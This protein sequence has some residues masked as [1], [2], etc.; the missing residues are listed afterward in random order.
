MNTT[1]LQ[2]RGL[3]QH[4][5]G[6]RALDGV[7]F[8]VSAGQ[9][10]ALI[11]PNGAGKSTCFA[12]LAG[13]QVPTAG[14][15]LWQGQ[16]LMGKPPAERQRL[17]VARTFQVAQTFEA[18]TVLQNIQ[19]VLRSA[20]PLAWWDRLDRRQPERALHLAAQA[21]LQSQAHA[22]VADLPYGAKKRLE[23]A[24]A[25]AGLP[26]AMPGQDAHCAPSLLLL[27]EP[28]AGLALAERADMMALVRQVAAQGVTVLYT[29][30][31]MDAV[32]GVADRVLVL[33]QG[34][35]VA[36]GLPDVVAQDPQVLQHYLGVNF[37]TAA[38]QANAL[39]PLNGGG[40]V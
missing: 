3:T 2:V 23:L 20:Q 33:M 30:H 12:C 17:G 5:G 11:G 18:L 34:R 10:V 36:D 35:L 21:G 31:N 40:H 26:E 25:L 16:S 22:T 19:L 1:V 15:V 14:E 27:D 13:Q 8:D 29:E 4:F 28:A 24:M 9:C 39:T 38:S 6:V 7:D 37:T 32:F